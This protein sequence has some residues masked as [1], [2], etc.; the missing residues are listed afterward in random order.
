MFDEQQL[1][2][3][4][5]YAGDLLQRPF[6]VGS[7]AED[8]CRHDG[9]DGGIGQRQALGGSV[10]DQC[11][12]ALPFESPS[13]FVAHSGFGLGQNEFV[14]RVGVVGEVQPGTGSIST[15][16]PRA[17][18][19]KARRR[20]RIPTISPSQRKGSYNTA[21]TRSQVA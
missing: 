15:T 11:G 2:V 20:R 10:E 1:A 6:R 8:E 4:P 18:A 16:R 13:E 14:H 3:G 12:T 7:G 21:I 17:R 9:V 5:E 19:S